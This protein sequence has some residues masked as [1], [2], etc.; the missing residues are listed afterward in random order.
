MTKSNLLERNILCSF[1]ARMKI[2]VVNIKISHAQK[3][4]IKMYNVEV[5]IIM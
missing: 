1:A 2:V 3:C 5:K 4:T